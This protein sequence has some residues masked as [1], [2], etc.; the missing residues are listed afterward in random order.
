[1]DRKTLRIAY[2]K[3]KNAI[4]QR[5]ASFRNLPPEQQFAEFLFCTLTPQSDARR[6]WSATTE[7]LALPTLSKPALIRILKT[8]T[9]FH[10]NKAAY[11]LY[12]QQNWQVIRE[13]LSNLEGVALR[14]WLSENV[15]GYGLKEASHFL[16]N[17]GLSQNKIAILDRHIL[18]NLHK[19]KVIKAN[20]ISIKSKAHYIALEKK[21][22]GFAN[23]TGIP[24]DHLDLLFWSNETGEVFK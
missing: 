23:K 24:P 14:N 11:V 22:I 10:N 19:H 18:R 21:F 1:M 2:R 17:I 5:L 15:K 9:R 7:I 12:N 3:K 6:C 4:V 16:R 8:K 13:Q 20:D